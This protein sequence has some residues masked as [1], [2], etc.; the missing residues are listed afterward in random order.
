MSVGSLG[1]IGGVAAVPQTQRQAANERTAGDAARNEG[2][3]RND[4][5]AELAA[6]IG[7]TD[8]E[9]HQT[10]ERDADGRMAWD[11]SRKAETAKPADDPVADEEPARS[12]DLSG[13]SG[14]TLDLLG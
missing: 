13:E 8:G 1:V 4:I 5:A 6:G 14:G 12:R 9:E 10:N 11:L 7:Q 2:E 3:V